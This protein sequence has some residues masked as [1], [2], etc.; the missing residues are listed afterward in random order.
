[1]TLVI[2]LAPEAQARLEQAA[3]PEGESSRADVAC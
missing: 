1:M 3:A 2:D